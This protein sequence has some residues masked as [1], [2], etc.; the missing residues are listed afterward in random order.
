MHLIHSSVKLKLYSL[1]TYMRGKYHHHTTATKL[2]KL[3]EAFALLPKF[4]WYLLVFRVQLFHKIYNNTCCYFSHNQSRI[5][6]HGNHSCITERIE[7][8]E[9]GSQPWVVFQGFYVMWIWTRWL[10][11][12]QS[13]S[14]TAAP[15]AGK[16]TPL[17]LCQTAEPENT[18]LNTGTIKIY[19]TYTWKNTPKFRD[20]MSTSWWK[21]TR[22]VP[23]VCLQ[24]KMPEP[25]SLCG[26]QSSGQ[27]V[28]WWESE[29]SWFH[30]AETWV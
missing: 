20:V 21:P 2:T 26:I 6:C 30:N 18:P 4:C 24:R 9:Y 5:G 7:N 16:I 27:M 1:H 25:V 15:R 11:L 8:I 22:V 28:L 3:E 13:R 23:L 10:F 14:E 12:Y 17:T 19:F 29:H